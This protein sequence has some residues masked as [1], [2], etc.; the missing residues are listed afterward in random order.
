MKTRPDAL[1]GQLQKSLA[2]I[3]YVTGDEPL[4]LGQACDQIR[5]A[6][7]RQGYT[8]R[9]VFYAERG[10]DWQLFG[11]STSNLS[12]FAE[13][14]L[15]DIRLGGSTPGKDGAKVLQEY[16]QHPAPDTILLL[17]GDKLESAQQRSAWFTALEQSGVIVQIWPI[18]AAQLPPWLVQRLQ[19]R[20][21]V[22]TLETAR[23]LADQVE[24][25]LLAA[26]QEIEKLA[27]LFGQGTLTLE[28][29]Q[30]SVADSARFDI[31][32]L[33]DE[34]LRGEVARTA[35]MIFGLQ[36]EG[37]DPV[38]VTWALTR[39]IRSLTRM[40]TGLA[41]G[42]SADAVI[43]QEHVWDK[44]KPLV[45][46]ALKRSQ[47]IDWQGLLR[48]CAQTDRIAKG[49]MSGR[50]WDELLELALGVAG[51]PALRISAESR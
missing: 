44:R 46:T 22:C 51:K 15:L 9:Q 23:C 19:Q 5:A 36:S 12:L 25:N 49:Q 42:Q 3:Y 21:L 13:R 17:S 37:A 33:V 31:F 28:Q 30:A 1:A 34:A 16:A 18:E 6:A 41:K 26:D 10:F 11:Q 48:H 47:L 45:K 38:L 35:R 4:Q 8:D 43:A 50:V 2:P 24:G 40:A 39:E 20:G 27:L 29:V 32:N 7:Q 14:K